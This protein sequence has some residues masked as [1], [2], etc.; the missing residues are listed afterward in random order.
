MNLEFSVPYTG[1]SVPYPG[2]V[3]ALEELL[4]SKNLNGN[5]IQY[6]IETHSLF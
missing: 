6:E 5:C 2:A 3:E 4:K 1:D